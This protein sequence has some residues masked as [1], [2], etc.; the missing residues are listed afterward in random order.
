[1][2]IAFETKMLRSICEREVKALKALGAQVAR[3]LRARL[4]DIDAAEHVAELVAGQPREH[5]QR[6]GVLR[7]DLCDGVFLRLA[8]NHVPVPRDQQ[9]MV[10][11]S[12]VSRLKL[13]SIEGNDG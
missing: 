1:M 7:I 3:H 2:L 10:R 12:K 11:W 9:G 5:G 6:S 13:L 8:V 4:A